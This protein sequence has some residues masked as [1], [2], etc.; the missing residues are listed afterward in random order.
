MSGKRVKMAKPEPRAPLYP[1]VRD[2][3]D[4]K[5]RFDQRVK[6]SRKRQVVSHLL[7]H[8]LEILVDPQ[9]LKAHDIKV[10]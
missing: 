5:K 7:P 9:L 1:G 10:R 3:S 2:A 4:Q 6:E 8:N